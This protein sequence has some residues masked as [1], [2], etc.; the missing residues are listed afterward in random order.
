[1][2]GDYAAHGTFD[3]QAKSRSLLFELN[4]R[5]GPVAA[6]AGLGAIAAVF[7]GT[8]GRRSD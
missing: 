2:P 5:R 4:R 8:N 6:A 3:D 1:V 7:L